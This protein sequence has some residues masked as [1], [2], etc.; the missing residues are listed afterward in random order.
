[1][2]NHRPFFG[3][4]LSTFRAHSAIQKAATSPTSTTSP[5]TS[6]Y[7][8]TAST[9]TTSNTPSAARNITTKASQSAGGATTVAL[10][11][12]TTHFTPTRQHSASPYSRSPG[13]GTSSGQG[14]LNPLQNRGRRGS[15]SSN[16]G[17]KESHGAEKWYIGGRTAAGEERIYKLSMVKRPRSIDRL[18][19]D[20]MSL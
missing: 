7:S 5:Q 19:L 10:Q 17:F 11:T 6:A 12:S 16:E 15:D 9:S 14:G 13:T 8:N 3:S 20:R 18:S 1:M 4:F 2:S